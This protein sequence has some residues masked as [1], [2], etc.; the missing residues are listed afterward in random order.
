MEHVRDAAGFNVTRTADVLA[1]GLWPSRGNEL[2]GFEVKVSRADWRK[3]LAQPEKA[4]GWCQ[5]VDRW[6]IVKGAKY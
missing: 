4:E 5:I 1:L 6:W 3:E 2:H